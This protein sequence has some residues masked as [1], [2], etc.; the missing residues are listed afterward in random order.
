MSDSQIITPNII[1]VDWGTTRFRAARLDRNGTVV[2]Q[3]EDPRGG[4]KQMSGNPADFEAYLGAQLA[5]WLEEA[6][7]TILMAGM[8][9]SQQGWIEAPYAQAPAGLGELAG[10]LARL[11]FDTAPAFIVPGVS[12]HAP[13]GTIDVMRGEETQ[14]MGAITLTEL[15]DA[16]VV[17]PGT[18]SK[19]ARIEKRRITGF[20]TSMTG[21]LFELLSQHSLLARTMTPGA[22][23]RDAFM[24][25]LERSET[26]GGL[27]HL[28]FSV[29]TEGLL[30]G[31]SGEGQ[32][33]FL[34]GI[35]I[36]SEIA[37]MRA[38]YPGATTVHL[39]A[40]PALAE[41]YQLALERLGMTATRL[42][43]AACVHAGLLALAAKAE[44]LR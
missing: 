10:K 29:R 35:L 2:D 17:L 1:A 42:D 20:A 16:L 41:P 8:I 22:F 15:D 32:H 44:L 21:E 14:I 18:H 9:G 24:A 4:I 5:P 30:N 37:A 36:G 11:P 27:A 33:S 3:V 39:V 26:T 6:A 40:G 23:Q 28:L 31:L 7:A 38:L 12:H 43:G 19:W 25:G 34:S 13:S